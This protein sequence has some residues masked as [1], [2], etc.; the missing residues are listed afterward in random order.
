MRPARAAGMKA[1]TSVTPTPTNNDA[2]MVRAEMIVDV[3]LRAESE[4]GW[5]YPFQTAPA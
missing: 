5:T 3:A 4:I 2:A 1:A